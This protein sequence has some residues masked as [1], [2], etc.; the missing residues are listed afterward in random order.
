MSH[1]AGTTTEILPPSSRNT[2]SVRFGRVDIARPG[3]GI[4]AA[5]LSAGPERPLAI[6]RQGRRATS[7]TGQ[8]G[9]PASHLARDG[10][11]FEVV[12]HWASK[13]GRG[14]ATQD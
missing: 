7:W 13:R 12:G 8:P 11:A 2:D 14:Q 6:C 4:S 10:P 1:G 5:W 3:V 9:G